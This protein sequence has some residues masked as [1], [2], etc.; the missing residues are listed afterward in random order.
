[1]LLN[2]LSSRITVLGVNTDAIF[3]NQ[4]AFSRQSSGQSF[5]IRLSATNTGGVEGITEIEAQLNTL[6]TGNGCDVDS[7]SI[8][9]GDS[10]YIAC[11]D[12]EDEDSISSYEFY[13]KVCHSVSQ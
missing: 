11:M 13:G 2:C 5:V 1:M 4:A 7:R 6:P 10:V 12:W 8:D 3:I 9:L